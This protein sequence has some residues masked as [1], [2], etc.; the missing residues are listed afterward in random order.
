M[1]TDSEIAP[2]STISGS[3][4]VPFL[5]A[6]KKA[7]KNRHKRSIWR[8]WRPNASQSDPRGSPKG[9]QNPSKIIP[10][11]SLSRR[12]LP[13]AVRGTPP[14]QKYPKNTAHGANFVEILGRVWI[15]GRTVKLKKKMAG[16]PP[17]IL[18]L[19]GIGNSGRVQTKKSGSNMQKKWRAFRP[20]FHCISG[21]IPETEEKNQFNRRGTP[22]N[23]PKNNSRDRREKTV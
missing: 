2:F 20:V 1:S 16:V 19:L 13:P 12:G 5:E 7:P 3:F 18:Y 8:L 14:P 10:K 22:Q 15:L 4:F 11:S 6:A 21:E 9:D 17:C 23:P